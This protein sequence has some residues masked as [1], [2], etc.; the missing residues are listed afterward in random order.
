MKEPWA[1][2]DA[3]QWT[4]MGKIALV[5][6]GGT[7][8]T[9]IADY[10][11][12]EIAWLTPADL[13]GYTAKRILRGARNLTRAGLENSGARLMPR[14]TVLFTSRAPI[15]YVAIAEEDVS[16]N[17]GFKSFVLRQDVLPD[18]IYY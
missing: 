5:V 2:P 13:S 9:K 11:G 12:G 14:D 16:T 8:D 18:F 10:F 6:G 4:Q 1:I 15:G 3:W 17:Q 7:P